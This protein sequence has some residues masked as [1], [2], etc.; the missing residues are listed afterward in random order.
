MLSKAWDLVKSTTVEGELLRPSEVNE[1]HKRLVRMR[2]KQQERENVVRTNLPLNATQDTRNSYRKGF[3]HWFS[4]MRDSDMA[5]EVF[6]Q[7]VLVKL[8]ANGEAASLLEY[9]KMWTRHV[10][11][12]TA[13]DMWTDPMSSQ[14]MSRRAMEL[15]IGGI[16]KKLIDTSVERLC[17]NDFAEDESLIIEQFNADEIKLIPQRDEP[18]ADETAH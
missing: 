11:R 15:R 12:N 6:Y 18:P 8:T 17:T 7:E 10:I 16:D 1:L 9:E 2:T 5:S 13:E 14:P 3:A 4:P